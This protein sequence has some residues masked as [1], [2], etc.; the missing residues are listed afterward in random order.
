MN[1][2]IIKS[3]INYFNPE[4]VLIFL[5][6]FIIIA[7]A[8]MILLKSEKNIW[9]KHGASIIT[10]VGIFFTFTGI[11]L[12]L[13]RFNPDDQNSLHQLIGGLKLAFI[14]ST[15][16]V[17]I[18][19]IFKWKS[20]A[21][22]SDSPLKELNHR[23]ALNT[24]TLGNLIL[25]LGNMDWQIEHR[26]NL[27]RTIEHTTRLETVLEVN[28]SQLSESLVKRQEQFNTSHASLET[29]IVNCQE[30]LTKVSN[31]L[32][33]TTERLNSRFKGLFDNATRQNNI[34]EDLQ[35]IYQRFDSCIETLEQ[36]RNSE[37]GAMVTNLRNI[38]RQEL[39]QLEQ[40]V[41]ASLGMLLQK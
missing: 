39:Q 8:G 32:H 22:S 26:T 17:L 20:S 40:S 27:E 38:L 18:S 19:I 33:I 25:V 41:T 9:Y 28:L 24:E 37:G 13:I 7:I 5:A 36:Y 15:V 31:D 4:Y 2:S 34:A 35:S 21:H 12:G 30:T 23:L 10:T 6:L 1:L 11:T 3:Y 14:P 16:A 29:I